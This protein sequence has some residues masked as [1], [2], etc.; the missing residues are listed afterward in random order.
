MDSNLRAFGTVISGNRQPNQEINPETRAAIISAVVAGDKKSH[1]AAR[2]SVSP[3]AVTRIIQRF[4]DSG[5]LKSSPRS[6]RPKSLSARDIRVIVR[7]VRL[8]HRITKK[9]LVEEL[10]LE[11]SPLTIYRALKD[12]DLRKWK[13]KKRVFLSKEAAEERLSWTQEWENREDELIQVCY[14]ETRVLISN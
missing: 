8:D 5:S 2:F 7:K 1:V 10:G 4:E 9:Q 11:V 12:E 3:S 14:V 6:G 13:A